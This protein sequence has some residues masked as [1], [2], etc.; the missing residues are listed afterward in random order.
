MI[1]QENSGCYKMENRKDNFDKFMSGEEMFSDDNSADDFDRSGDYS[2][3]FSYDPDYFSQIN[4]NSYH[5]DKNMENQQFLTESLNNQITVPESGKKVS[6]SNSDQSLAPGAWYNR[7]DNQYIY[8]SGINGHDSFSAQTYPENTYNNDNNSISE[9]M[10]VIPVYEHPKISKSFIKIFSLIILFS[11]II[12][13]CL[14]LYTFISSFMEAYGER[15]FASR[16]VETEGI[17]RDISDRKTKR[18]NSDYYYYSFNV[19]YSINAE[20]YNTWTVEINQDRALWL[21]IGRKTQKGDHL[22]IYVDPS[23][24]TYVKLTTNPKAKPQTFMMIIMFIS[25]IVIILSIVDM[26]RRKRNTPENWISDQEAEKILMPRDR[27]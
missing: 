20:P 9:S 11:G 14:S 10:S 4:D 1:K 17:V 8:D 26:I 24:P 6:Q 23:N 25:L 22:K 21:G 15:A 13:F 19:S 16:C 7:F 27:S 5:S 18:F 12:V 3:G 2:E